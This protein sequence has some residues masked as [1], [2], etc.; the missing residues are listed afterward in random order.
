MVDA[1]S[2]EKE[3]HDGHFYTKIR[4]YQCTGDHYL[5]DTWWARLASISVQKKKNLARLLRNPEYRSAFDCQ[6]D[7]PGLRGGM[8]L[9]TIHT[10]LSMRC[11]EV[12][13]VH[14]IRILNQTNNRTGMSPVSTICQ[15]H[16]VY[17]LVTRYHGHAE[18]GHFDRERG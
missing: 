15:A 17:N 18:I 2:S 3:P 7:M 5:E 4:H 1:Y 6:I 9:G 10:M 8:K 12:R 14:R 16:L 13:N 11:D